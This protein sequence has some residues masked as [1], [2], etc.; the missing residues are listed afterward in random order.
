MTNKKD[1]GCKTLLTSPSD[2]ERLEKIA[3]LEALRYSFRLTKHNIT[4]V[5]YI[6]LL[7]EILDWLDNNHYR[8]TTEHLL[9]SIEKSAVHLRE[10]YPFLPAISHFTRRWQ[11]RDWSTSAKK[12]MALKRRDKKNELPAESRLLAVLINYQKKNQFAPK[13]KIAREAGVSRKTAY[14]CPTFLSL[15]EE[16]KEHTKRHKGTRYKFDENRDYS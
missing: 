11:V 14:K 5:D 8:S 10:S 7:D 13:V 3:S 6:S 16:F 1:A 2:Y 4:I 12:E 9:D 15:F